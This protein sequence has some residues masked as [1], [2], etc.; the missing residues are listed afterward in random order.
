[1]IG[2]QREG[3]MNADVAAL[4]LAIRPGV[5]DA[6]HLHSLLAID[7]AAWMR[8][9]KLHRILIAK[10][11]DGCR[12]GVI[13]MIVSAGI[14]IDI[15]LFGRNQDGYAAIEVDTGIAI[16]ICAIVSQVHVGGQQSAFGCLEDIAILP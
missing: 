3:A 15:Q 11:A 2:G 7:M 14:D 13:E 12:V 4:Q 8:S 5:Y 16:D 10:S 9:D 1:M 6:A